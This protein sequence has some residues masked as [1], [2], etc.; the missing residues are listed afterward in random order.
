MMYVR[1]PFFQIEK[2]L[3]LLLIQV[4]I[5]SYQTLCIDFRIPGDVEFH[6]EARWLEDHG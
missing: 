6:E 1:I 2:I 5:T 4:I 3:Q